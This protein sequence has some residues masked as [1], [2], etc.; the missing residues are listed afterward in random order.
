MDE[1]LF[2][3]LLCFLGDYFVMVFVPYLHLRYMYSG[4]SCDR[5]KDSEMQFFK[6]RTEHTCFSLTW[7][8]SWC[9]EC[10]CV[11]LETQLL[12]PLA[13]TEE[14]ITKD[15]QS[16]YRILIQWEHRRSWCR[17]QVMST[18]SCG[19]IVT[20]W[21]HTWKWFLPLLFFF[22]W[23]IQLTETVKCCFGSVLLCC[24]LY[25]TFLRARKMKK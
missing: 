18:H 6:T 22:S 15:C 17:F 3:C 21:W 14:R 5:L 19:R 1:W 8:G 11:F 4:C 23:G 24:I 13:E 7:W 12:C 2:I 16:L 9:F 10:F 25:I 20:N